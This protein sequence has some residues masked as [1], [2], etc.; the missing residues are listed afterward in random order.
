MHIEN[1]TASM[2]MASRSFDHRA[3]TPLPLS[4]TFLSHGTH[5]P[6]RCLS[7]PVGEYHSAVCAVRG[8]LPRLQHSLLVESIVP[9]LFLR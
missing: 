8:R 7:C 3:F 5:F 4:V 1:L 2:H 6:F 9:R